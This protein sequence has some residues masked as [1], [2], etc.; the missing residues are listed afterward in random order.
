MQRWVILRWTG[1]VL[2]AVLL[3]AAAAAAGATDWLSVCGRC[4]SP[5]ITT[6]SGIGTANAVAEARITRGD[7]ESYCETQGSGSD[8]RSCVREQMAS[9]EARRSYRA[10]ADCTR[11][12]ITPIDGRTYQ[13]AGTWGQGDIGAGRTRWRGP[14]GQIVGRDNAS[15]GL[16]ISQQWEVLCPGPLRVAGP[17][18]A[19]PATRSA[20]APAVLRVAPPGSGQAVAAGF[21]VG[22]IVEARYGRQWVRGRVTRLWRTTGPRGPEISYDVQLENGIRGVLP[23][24]MMRPA[25]G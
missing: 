7:A 20:A 23:V 15:N 25:G 13:L 9:E 10:S 19:V 12:R 6:R 2:P 14:N 21:A 17:G 11:G 16:A 24:H 22:Q 8:T 5:S 1:I 3:A 4:L 18:A